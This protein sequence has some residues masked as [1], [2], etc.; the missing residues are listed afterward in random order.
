MPF[1]HMLGSYRDDPPKFAKVEG[2][3]SKG[4]IFE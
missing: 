3:T 2:D 1:D 4:A